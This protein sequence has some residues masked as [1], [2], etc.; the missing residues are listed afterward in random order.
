MTA[1]VRVRVLVAAAALAVVGAAVG[2]TLAT[3][4]PTPTV[5]RPKGAPPLSLDLG[6]RTD[7][8]A[9]A[10]SQAARL[11]DA[12]KRSEAG[13]IFARYSSVEAEVGAALSTWPSGTVTRL[14]ALTHEHPKSAAVELNLGLAR[15]WEGDSTGAAAAFRAAARLQPDTS[16]AVQADSLLHPRFYRG[17]P[18]FTPSFAVPAALAKLPPAR[19]LAA[20]ARRADAGSVRYRLLYGA[21]LQGLGRPVSAERQF[22][23]AAKA[24][25]DDPEALT[26]AAVGRFSKSNPS[27]AFSRL[28]PLAKRFPHAATIRFHLGEMLVWMAQVTEA[29]KQFRL[30]VADDPKGPIGMEAKRFLASLENVGTK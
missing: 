2:I 8:E 1:R 16:Y 23:L 10:L 12:G 19:Q 3:R 25:P 4:T 28:G 30:A 24:A 27:V 13:K 26:A 15:V 9:R 29:K 20:L 5:Q 14:E 7:P 18:P 6:L 11:Y 21:T 22:A 17:L